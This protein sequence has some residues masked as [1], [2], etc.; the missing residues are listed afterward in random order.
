MT[1]PEPPAEERISCLM[2]EIDEHSLRLDTALTF[3]E[4]RTIAATEE[5]HRLAR[6]IHDG[7]AQEVASLGYLVNDLAATATDEIQRG[8]L[9]ELRIE[10]TKVVGDYGCRSSTCAARS[11]A[12]AGLGAALSEYVRRVG[13]RSDMTVHLTLDEAPD[14]LRRDVETE[15]LRIAQEAITNARKRYRGGEP[16]GQL[17]CASAVREVGGQGR[18]RRSG[19]GARRLLRHSNHARACRTDLSPLTDRRRLQQ[20]RARHARHR[21]SWQSSEHQPTEEI[22]GEETWRA[23][24]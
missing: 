24:R 18:R 9:R 23:L 8:K 4:V 20:I 16:L 13:S 11:D 2:T 22:K 19:C 14:R 15:V 21:H 10:L 3:D 6:E 12:T 1:R 17:P 5:R 7:V